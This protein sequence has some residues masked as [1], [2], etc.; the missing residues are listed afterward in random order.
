MSYT[1]NKRELS[2]PSILGSYRRFWRGC[3]WREFLFPNSIGF[4]LACQRLQT[5]ADIRALEPR[6]GVYEFAISKKNDR[7]Y[8][9]YIGESSSIRRRHQ[10]YAQTGDHLL[11]IFDAALKNGCVIWRR[12]RYVKTKGEAVS[13]EAKF[14]Q[15]YDYAW[16]A[17]QNGRKRA[18]N[19]VS[20]RFC[21]CMSSMLIIEDPVLPKPLRGQLVPKNLGNNAAHP[22]SPSPK[23]RGPKTLVT[24]NSTRG[25]AFIIA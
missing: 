18:V 13:K 11:A 9:T 22:V 8:K 6:P 14:L 21:L 16:N 12:C 24:G 17:Q 3:E 4:T 2:H 7:R 19:I 15:K 23:K 1:R 10:K 5:H 20:Q 25:A